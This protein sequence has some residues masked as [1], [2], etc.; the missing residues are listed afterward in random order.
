MVKIMNADIF[1]KNF[2]GVD[3]KTHRPF[4][5]GHPDGVW[6]ISIIYCILSIGCLGSIV[7]EVYNLIFSVKFN[8]QLL[9]LACLVLAALASSVFF[10]F[11][12]RVKAIFVMFGLFGIITLL[13]FSSWMLSLEVVWLLAVLLMFQLIVI[14]Y[15]F[16]LRK[17]KLLTD[18]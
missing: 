3:P 9:V 4:S 10:L 16:G 1:D 13:L 17:D 5:A 6:I 14:G 7:F 8:I 18:K 11:K 15:S 12:R 2:H